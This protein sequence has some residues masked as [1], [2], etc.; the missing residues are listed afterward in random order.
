MGQI[1]ERAKRGRAF[2]AREEAGWESGGEYQ[3]LG[4]QESIQQS[5][6]RRGRID[7]VAHQDDGTKV[8]VETKATDWETMADYRVRPNV[9]R[10]IRQLMRYVYYFVDQG[11]GVHPAL[12]YHQSPTNP[13]RKQQVEEIGLEACVE[14]I[15]RDD[16]SQA[17]ITGTRAS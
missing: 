16:E 12:V 15:W 5:S 7:I 3:N 9:L 6:A 1:Q 8:V 10:H 2:E 4:S 17:D 13:E 11:I 14:V